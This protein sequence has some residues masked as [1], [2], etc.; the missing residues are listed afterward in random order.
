MRRLHVN[1]EAIE[2]QI[3]RDAPAIAEAFAKA[4]HDSRNE[5]E[6]RTH[7]T[8]VIEGF[9]ANIGLELSLREEYAVF[10]GRADAVYNRF[11]IEYERPGSLRE[12]NSYKPNQ[13]AINQVKAYIE[14]IVQRERHK[15]KRL[16]GVAFDGCYYI[17]VRRRDG[18]WHVDDPLEVHPP[19]TERFLRA[20]ASLSTERALIPENLVEDFGEGSQI[21]RQLASALYEGLV[22]TDSPRVRVLFEQWSRQFGEVCDYETASKVNVAGIARSYGIKAQKVDPFRLFFCIHTYYAVLIKALASQVAHFY[23]MPKLATDLKAVGNR[24]PQELL[25]YFRNLEEGELF[26]QLGIANFLEADF[27]GWYLDSWTASVEGGVRELVNTLANYSLVT[28]D[29]DPDTT[30]DL[31]KQLYQNLMPKQLRH[32]LGEYYTPDWLAQRLLNQLDGGTFRGDPDK[33][34]LDPACGSGTFLVL[35]IKAIREYGWK[36]TVREA[37]L[38]EKILNNVV[39]FDLNPLA[40]VSARTNYLLALGDLL[41]HRRGEITIPVYL[42]DSILT[43]SQ[44]YAHRGVKDLTEHGVGF[45]TSVGRFALPE[46]LVDARYVDILAALLEESVRLHLPADE[47][48]GRATAALPLDA[49]K[50]TRDYSLLR[51]LYEKL[52]D[53]DSKGV[54]GIWARIIKNAFAPL[55][56]GQFDF[57]AGNPPWVNWEHLPEQYRND[58]KPLWQ[59]YGLFTL[60]GHAARLGGGKKDISMLMF[61]AAADRYL[62]PR[63]LIGFVITQTVFKTEGGGEGFRRFKL[64]ADGTSLRVQFLDDMSAIKPFEGA[65][66][67]TAV[68]IARKGLSTR[69]PVQVGYWRKKQKGASLP[70]SADIDEVLNDICRVSQWVG[71]PVDDNR[72]DSPW[73]TGRPR[74]LKAVKRIVGASAYRAREGCNTGGL[75]G[76]YWVERVAERPDGLVVVA[77]CGDIGK[78]EAECIQRAVEP[79]SV[80]LLLR[81]QDVSRWRAAPSLSLVLAQDEEAPSSRAIPED[82]LRRRR[83]HTLE[84]FRLFEGQLRTRSGYLKYLTDQAFYAVYNSGSYVFAPWKVVWREQAAA[85]TCAVVGP[86]GHRA[87]VPD[88]KLMLVP[89]ES[90]AEAHFVCACLSSSIAV[91]VVASY[92]LETSTTTHVLN[93]VPVAKYEPREKTHK[94]LALLSQRC[95]AAAQVADD[96]RLAECEHEINELTAQ[97]WGLSASELRDIE[98]SLTDLMA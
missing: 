33:R 80:Y 10:E 22:T 19:S 47:F 76:A 34:L 73:I 69:Y 79:G 6:L 58:T 54:N 37:D 88:H 4:R 39:G 60:T 43:P 17:L 15:E 7:A 67:R 53:L 27:F 28:L 85:L 90:E 71:E 46:S 35:A 57:V 59:R 86:A 31:L 36:N 23:L 50:D 13:H 77:N 20:L 70:E 11:I 8:R 93:Y 84:Y 56:C 74:S 97:L 44:S 49:E 14:G 25:A 41:Q 32:N 81:G 62:K 94:R 72:P 98:G 66:N 45:T 68:V 16:A 64:G 65:A 52:L 55:F 87:V 61:Y 92:A 29:V 91:Y 9:A 75:N 51:A 96:A 5:A 82:Q 83:P 18:V 63:G 89:C 30:R 3:R 95:H 40:V 78:I 26:R 24:S 42:C 2:A 1:Q 48:I 12:S 21:S 38:L